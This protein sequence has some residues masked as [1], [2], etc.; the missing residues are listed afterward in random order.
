MI[1][2][3][4][5]AVINSHKAKNAPGVPLIG[6]IP[7]R[8]DRG[9]RGPPQGGPP[10]PPGPP[11]GPPGPPGG[12][13]LQ[14]ILIPTT[15]CLAGAKYVTKNSTFICLGSF[16]LCFACFGPP[17]PPGGCFLQPLLIPTT[18]CLAG[19]NYV[20]K[21]STF[22]IFC[23]V[24]GVFLGS[25]SAY[26]PYPGLRAGGGRVGGRANSTPTGVHPPPTQDCYPALRG[27]IGPQGPWGTFL[28]HL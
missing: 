25:F 4:P 6:G 1:N 28:E 26:F 17:G 2:S 24:F 12:C 19:A 15:G 27:K 13:F 18:S 9:N 23:A 21:N 16:L 20:T 10:G 8:E 3:Y 14:P 5:A 11:Q 7:R 22:F